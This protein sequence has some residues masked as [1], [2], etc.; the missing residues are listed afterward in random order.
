MT[1]THIIFCVAQTAQLPQKHTPGAVCRDLT[2][3]EDIQIAPGKIILA[4]TGVKIACAAGR[5]TKIYARS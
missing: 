4:P 3:N 1:H 5:H 2:I